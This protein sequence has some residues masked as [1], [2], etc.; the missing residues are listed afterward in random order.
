MTAGT[1]E[2]VNAA[3]GGDFRPEGRVRAILFDKDGTLIDFQKTWGP[4]N[5][6]AAALAARGDETL[7]DHLMR[8]GGLDPRTGLTAADSLLAA[9]NTLEIAEAWIAAGSAF[10]PGELAAALDDLFTRS[11]HEAVPVT[12]LHTLFARLKAR[13]L[14][15]GIAS[16][17]SEPSIRALATHLAITTHLDFVAGYDSGHGVKPGGGMVTAFCRA[18]GVPPAETVVV[19]DNLHDMAMGRAGAAA[20][21][22][23]VLTGTGTEETLAAAADV[24]LP[25]IDALEAWLDGV[26]AGRPVPAA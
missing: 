8:V 4:L 16:S 11:A 24:C 15:L 17:D 2:A 14:K 13:G 9:A 5:R 22:I 18:V 20:A 6:R 23:G 10:A 1:G 7:A 21:V 26:S 12:D 25:G 19:G 3:G